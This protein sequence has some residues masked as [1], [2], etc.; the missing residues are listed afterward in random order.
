MRRNHW[1]KMAFTI[2]LL[3]ASAMSIAQQQTESRMR[4]EMGT[5][6]QRGMIVNV[7][8]QPANPGTEVSVAL[9]ITFEFGSAQLT[10][11]GRN[12]LI[13]TASALNSQELVGMSF[14]VEGHTDVVGPDQKNLPLSQRRADAVKGF[15]VSQGV[16]A[17]RLATVGYG[18]SRPI[19]NVV[20]TDGR[21]RRVEIVRRG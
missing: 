18:E 1:L 15:L 6:V 17:V 4:S 11:Q 19:P 20:G 3:S 16:A 8:Q 21:Q 7:L 14:I 10:P 12:I 5:D 2:S 9:P 13:T